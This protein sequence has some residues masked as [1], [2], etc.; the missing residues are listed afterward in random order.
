MYEEPTNP[1]RPCKCCGA[2]AVTER[3]I[4]LETCGCG[5]ELK[6]QLAI[7]R[8]CK[9][10]NTFTSHVG[11]EA[12]ENYGIYRHNPTLGALVRTVYFSTHVL[13]GPETLEDEEFHVADVEVTEEE[14]RATLEK[15]RK[16]LRA[17]VCN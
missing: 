15:Q 17:L 6:T 4:K 7:C 3:V 16:T 5:T 1:K 10:A 9:D 11:P 14:F 13:V 8:L 2:I 12:P